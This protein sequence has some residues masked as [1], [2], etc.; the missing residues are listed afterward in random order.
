LWILNPTRQA[1]E[2]AHQISLS[3]IGSPPGESPRPFGRS[4]HRGAGQN[5]LISLSL[6]RS[7]IAM[8]SKDG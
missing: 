2:I 8:A 3:E 6:R 5:T 4:M 7:G 1:N